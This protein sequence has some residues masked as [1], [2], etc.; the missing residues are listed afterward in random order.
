MITEQLI[1][2]RGITNIMIT[3][4]F[5]HNTQQP[6]VQMLIGRADWMT[7]MPPETARELAFNLLGAAD[8]AESDGFLVGFFRETIG[9]DDMRAVASLL[10]QFREY[11]EKRAQKTEQM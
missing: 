8:A 6:Y 3:S 7:Q 10:I 9:I 1:E 4:G 11:R 5:G 2:E